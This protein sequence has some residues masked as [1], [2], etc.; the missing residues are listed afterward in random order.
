MPVEYHIYGDGELLPEL[1]RRVCE[2]GLEEFVILHGVLPYDR[3][4]GAM[5]EA[6]VFVGMGTALV[7][8]AARGV[9]ALTAIE[10]AKDPITQGYLHES[11]GYHLGD[12]IEGKQEYQMSD[13]IEEL[14]NLS[15][16]QYEE[17]CKRSRQRAAEFSIEGVTDRLLDALEASAPFRYEITGWM[18]LRDELDLWTWRVLKAFGVPDPYRSRYARKA[19]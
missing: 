4:A 8:A 5:E 10:S 6:A 1:K 17:V 18:R 7:E 9:P 2:L 14:I 3:F 15:P 13:K 16:A 11:T 19:S 12:Y